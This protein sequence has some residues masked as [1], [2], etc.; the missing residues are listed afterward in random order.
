ME[1]FEGSL[2]LFAALGV[3]RKARWLVL[4]SAYVSTWLTSTTGRRG[5]VWLGSTS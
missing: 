2:P 1:R 4:N 3:V 5:L